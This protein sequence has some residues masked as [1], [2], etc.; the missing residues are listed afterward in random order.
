MVFK[1]GGLAVKILVEFKFGGGNLQRI[2]SSYTLCACFSL[3]VLEQCREFAK[4][5]WECTSAKLAY[6]C[7]QATLEE[8][9]MAWYPLFAHARKTL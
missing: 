9:N 5:N 8:G 1:F 4:Y 7:N 3:E 2:M 6:P